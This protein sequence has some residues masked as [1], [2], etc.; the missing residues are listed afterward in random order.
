M[1]FSIRR[2]AF[3][4][5]GA[6]TEIGYPKLAGRAVPFFDVD[7]RQPDGSPAPVGEPGEIWVRGDAVSQGYWR[8]P[9]ATAESYAGGWFFVPA[10]WPS[11][12]PTV[13]SP[14]STASTTWIISGG[15]NVYPHEV[16]DVIAEQTAVAEVAVIGVP[17]AKWGEAVKACVVLR[18]QTTLC[19]KDLQDHCAGRGLAPYKKPLSLDIMEQI[20]KTAVGKISRRLLRETYWLEQERRVG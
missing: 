10:T 1:Q 11:A 4:D 5:V 9:E 15:F 7:L 20:P 19:L 6:P 17:D 12:T 16:E 14:S 2:S 18:P 13:T 3:E 8:R